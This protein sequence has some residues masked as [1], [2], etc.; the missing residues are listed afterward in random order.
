MFLHSTGNPK[1]VILA[2]NLAKIF[3]GKEEASAEAD[4]RL[5]VGIKKADKMTPKELI[6]A[7]DPEEENAVFRRLRDMSRGQ[8]CSFRFRKSVD[9]ETTLKLLLEA[10]EPKLCWS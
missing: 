7:L 9:V 2:N 6:E 4:K 1:P 3:R 5:G 8:D 10:K